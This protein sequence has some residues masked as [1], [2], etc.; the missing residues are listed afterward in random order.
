MREPS[1]PEARNLR[2]EVQALIEQ[3]AVQEA[4]SSACRIRHQSSAW[5]D[6]DAQDQ[7]A[8][9]HAG[10]A[11]GWPANQGGTPVRERILDTR[12]QAQDC[13]ARNV[14][15]F[16]RRGNAEMRVAAGYH[17]RRRASRG[18]TPSL[19]GPIFSQKNLYSETLNTSRPGNLGGKRRARK[20]QR[21]KTGESGIA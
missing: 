11:A 5:D 2:R 8:S 15:N 20:G 6:G 4:E 19:N 7:E 21:A 18:V 9:I 1:T 16:R 10:G 12:G 17:P 13:D 14:I 3:E